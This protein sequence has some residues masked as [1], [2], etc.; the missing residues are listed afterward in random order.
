MIVDRC[1]L[2]TSSLQIE[3][4]LLQTDLGHETVQK[5]KIIFFVTG[6]LAIMNVSIASVAGKTLK[7]QWMF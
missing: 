3:L 5:N 7:L 4:D 1:V 2:A 6:N